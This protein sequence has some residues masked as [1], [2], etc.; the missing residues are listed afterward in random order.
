MCPHTCPG[1]HGDSSLAQFRIRCHNTCPGCKQ[2][3]KYGYLNE[4]LR[5]CH[6]SSAMFSGGITSWAAAKRVAAEH[7]ADNT[8][9]L[10]TD[11]KMEDED[12]YRFRGCGCFSDVEDE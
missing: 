10:F 6:S 1:P 5:E 11:T 8:L 9:L 7:G 12:L 2:Q 3:I 4:H